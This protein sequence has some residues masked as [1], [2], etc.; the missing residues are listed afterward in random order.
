MTLG[1]DGNRNSLYVIDGTVNPPPYSVREA[2][3]THLVLSLA[4]SPYAPENLGV[5]ELSAINEVLLLLCSLAL[6][7]V[8]HEVT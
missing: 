7:L 2:S 4:Q 6:L 8:F 1:V 3:L 5:T